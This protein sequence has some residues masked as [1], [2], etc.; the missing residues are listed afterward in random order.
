MCIRDRDHGESLPWHRGDE[1]P[2]LGGGQESEG[3]DD[4]LPKESPSKKQARE[5]DLADAQV[6]DA[7]ISQYSTCSRT[8]R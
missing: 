3:A 1:V 6:Q 8:V 4:A 7:K 5:G 2:E